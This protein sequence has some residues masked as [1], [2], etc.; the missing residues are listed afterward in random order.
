MFLKRQLEELTRSG[1]FPRSFDSQ[2]A[3]NSLT[4]RADGMFLWA[5]LMITYLQIRALTP[6]HRLDLVMSTSLPEG[7]DAMYNRISEIICSQTTLEKGLAKRMISLLAVARYPLTP[8][9]FEMAINVANGKL[10][11]DE[12]ERLQRFAEVV[13]TVCGGVVELVT[14]K[15]PLGG[16]VIHSFQFVHLSA[17]EYFTKELSEE[18][19][20]TVTTTG[21]NFLK[22][23]ML[24]SHVEMAQICLTT[25][26]LCPPDQPLCLHGGSTGN[27]DVGRIDLPFTHYAATS[28]IWHLVETTKDISS[29]AVPSSYSTYQ[30]NPHT[31]RAFIKTLKSFLSNPGAVTAWLHTTY[32]ISHTPESQALLEWIEEIPDLMSTNQQSD[33]FKLVL[34]DTK[35]LAEDLSRLKKTWGKAL[36]GNPIYIWDEAAAY[37][38][39]R[40]LQPSGATSFTE[41]GHNRTNEP[42]NSRSSDGCFCKVSSS[43][44]TSHFVAILSIWPSR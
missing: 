5:R 15:N 6:R 36:R 1:L 10:A 44:L 41:V 16:Q 38:S 37:L 35:E 23:S 18:N 7:L 33:A 28:W 34:D 20:M 32:S 42:S 39:S 30:V 3:L 13:V 26:E 24:N 8:D 19:G 14:L 31:F 43:N 9:D 29:S 11:I 27:G 2:L 21:A 4:R 17:K 25:I 12:E 22:A 40:F